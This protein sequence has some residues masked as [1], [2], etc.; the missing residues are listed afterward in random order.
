MD[1]ESVKNIIR[2]WI[3]RMNENEIL[4]ENILALNFDYMNLMVSK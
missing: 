1:K 3:K 2:A 4:P